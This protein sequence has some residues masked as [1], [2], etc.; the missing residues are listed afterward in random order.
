MRPDGRVVAMVGGKRYADSPFNRVTQARRQ[1]GSAF[2][3]FVYLAA[4]RAGWTPDSMIDDSPVT[5]E[6]WTPVNSDRIYRGRISL[7]EAFARSSNAAT[8]RLSQSVGR[9]NVIRAA[10]DLGITTPLPDKPSL[11]LGTAGVSLLELTSAYAAIAGGRYPI[12]ARGLPDEQPAE[13]LSAFFRSAGALDRQ[14]DWAP[15]L[16]LLYA[17]ANNGTGRRAALNVPTFGKTGTTQENRDALFVGFAGDLVVGVW[18]GRDDNKSLG[19]ISGGTVPAEIWRSFMSSALAVD[20]NRGPLLPVEFQRPEPQRQLK[21]PLPPE[22]SN[23][24]KP[25]RELARQLEDLVGKP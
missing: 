9:A 20:R 8:V 18:V 10:R 16:D 15:M 7:R 22:W 5:I 11:A 13:G 25:L 1:P 4:L 12:A 3:L 21:S 24:T 17:A 19:K 2:K 14:R 6:G 23:A